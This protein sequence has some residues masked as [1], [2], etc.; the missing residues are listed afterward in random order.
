MEKQNISED[1]I[2][3]FLNDVTVPSLTAEQSLSFEGNSQR[4]K[5]TTL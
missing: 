1:S 3:N 5:F 2:C 4:K